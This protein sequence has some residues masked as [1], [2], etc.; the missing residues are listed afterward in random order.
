MR[1]GAGENLIKPEILGKNFDKKG[2]M[3]P[4]NPHDGN[5]PTLLTAGMSSNDD[6]KTANFADF[7]GVNGQP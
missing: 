6:S 2:G 7:S 1:R 5:R 4:R 3:M